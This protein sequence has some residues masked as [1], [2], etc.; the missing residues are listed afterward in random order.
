MTT[1]IRSTKIP[2]RTSGKTVST[3]A[4]KKSS[5]V[6]RRRADVR[7]L[8]ILIAV[9]AV[10]LVFLSFPR[11]TSA[12]SGNIPERNKYFTCITIEYGDTLWEIAGE[13]ITPE[14]SD[15]YDYIDEVMQI[16]HLSSTVI[17]TGMKLCVPYYV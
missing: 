3:H 13:Y 1:A 10:M 2:R 8:F 16:N 14:Y 6:R 17:K 11:Q 9:L 12:S 7:I 15:Y 4:K 5:V